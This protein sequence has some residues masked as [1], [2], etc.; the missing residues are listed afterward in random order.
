MPAKDFNIPP[1]YVIEQL[2]SKKIEGHDFDFRIKVSVL[3]EVLEI[4]CLAFELPLN[5]QTLMYGGQFESLKYYIDAFQKLFFYQLP[6]MVNDSLKIE[7][8]ND[9]A[10]AIKKKRMN[11]DLVKISNHYIKSDWFQ[12]F[13]YCC[14]T[15]GNKLLPTEAQSMNDLIVLLGDSRNNDKYSQSLQYLHFGWFGLVEPILRTLIP[16]LK[17]N[18]QKVVAYKALKKLKGEHNH[19]F[20]HKEFFLKGNEKNKGAIIE[21]LSVYNDDKTYWLLMSYYNQNKNKLK[22][23]ELK[24]LLSAFL[25]FKTDK[26]E[27]IAWEFLLDKNRTAGHHAF[28]MLKKLEFSE[29]E[30]SK[31]LNREFRNVENVAKFGSIFFLFKKIRNEFLI[32]DSTELIDGLV[33]YC[34]YS[35]STNISE[36]VAGLLIQNYKKSL[37]K[38]LDNLLN[39]PSPYVKGAI[40]K[41]VW[42]LYTNSKLTPPFLLTHDTY[43]KI[44]NLCLDDE[45]NVQIQAVNAVG[46]IAKKRKN[47][48]VIFHLLRTVDLNKI[49]LAKASME[50]INLILSVV[51]FD[52]AIL[53]LYLEALKHSNILIKLSAINGIKYSKSHNVKEQ[54]LLL[55]DDP[56]TSIRSAVNQAL[57]FG[58]ERTI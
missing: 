15:T 49:S 41:I 6:F 31:R 16:F 45:M 20:L 39:H 35:K 1:M 55:K 37:S 10:N 51:P 11:L 7:E 33:M 27:T 17:I 5:A 56:N 32:P 4:E 34:E 36:I 21:G 42:N 13:Y 38:K 22:E 2:F 26:V 19:N 3:G 12:K 48:L 54:L 57:K 23:E 18:H 40:L 8:L 50:A 52:D 14:K 25:N 58:G 29:Y 44:E 53:P 24:S 47:S 9:V 43:L 28:K 46:H 30:I